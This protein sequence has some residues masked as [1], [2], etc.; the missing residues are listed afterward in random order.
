[1]ALIQVRQNYWAILAA[2]L[3]CFLLAAGWFTAFMMPWLEGTGRTIEWLKATGVSPG[4]QYG[5]AFVAAVVVAA[6]ISWF[7]QASGEQ[8]MLRGVLIGAL[9]WFGLVLPTWVTEYIYEVRPISLLGINAGFWLIAMMMQGA[10]V[11][12][13]KKKA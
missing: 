9:L 12:G 4:M 5:T 8:T 3:A 2:G 10:I 1:M 6:A 7:T 11:G 13:W